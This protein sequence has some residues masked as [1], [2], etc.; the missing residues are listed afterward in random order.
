MLRF[1]TYDIYAINL[2]TSIASNKQILNLNIIKKCQQ[3][4]IVLQCYSK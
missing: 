3:I 1:D 2:I 4:N